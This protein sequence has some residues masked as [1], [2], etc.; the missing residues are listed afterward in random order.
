MKVEEFFALLEE[1]IEADPGTINGAEK[2]KD[3]DGWDSLAIVSFIAMVDERFEITL[4]PRKIADS[5]L[6]SDLVTLLG[7]NIAL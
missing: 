5:K 7:D 6:I 4:S 3:L 2:L 1:I